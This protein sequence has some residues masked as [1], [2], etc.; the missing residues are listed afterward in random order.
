[1]MKKITIIQ[2][3]AN[4]D[5]NET[6]GDADASLEAYV[7]EVTAALR[8]EFPDCEVDHV[9]G[10]DT[11]SFRLSTDD[12]DNYNYDCDTIQRTLETVYET[13]KFWR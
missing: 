3:A 11:Y 1:M 5:P 6:A 2:N 9:D 4:L 7:L 8:N 12:D 10:D 13:G